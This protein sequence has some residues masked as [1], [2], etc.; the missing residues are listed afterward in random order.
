MSSANRSS[1]SPSRSP[2]CS[3]HSPSRSPKRDEGRVPTPERVRVPDS[4]GSI[5]KIFDRASHTFSQQ[6]TIKLD[7]KNFLSWKQQVEGVIRGH[8]LHP[9]VI[10]PSIPPRFLTVRDRDVDLVNPAYTEWEQQDSLLFTWLLS[11]LSETILPRV[12]RCVHSYQV[13]DEIHKY[14]QAQMNA[15]SRQ[16]I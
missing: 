2:N 16:L 11:T 9:F 3:N 1:R 14:F 8:K 10:N 15:R 7:S 6:I 13:R 12:V 5:W 4:G